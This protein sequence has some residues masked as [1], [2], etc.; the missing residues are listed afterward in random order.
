M[1]EFDIKPLAEAEKESVV[2]GTNTEIE[3]IADIQSLLQSFHSTNIKILETRNK[4]STKSRLSSTSS[5]RDSVSPPPSNS[6]AD[7][8]S[9]SNN[10]LDQS[11]QSTTGITRRRKSRFEPQTKE[12]IVKTEQSLLAIEKNFST[13]TNEGGNGSMTVCPATDIPIHQR[14]PNSTIP[15]FNQNVL[16]A[17]SA[18]TLSMYQ[19][20][21]VTQPGYMGPNQIVL[22][23]FGQQL[24]YNMPQYPEEP[25]KTH[26][27]TQPQAPATRLLTDFF[28]KANNK[29]TT[30]NNVFSSEIGYKSSMLEPNRTA[31][32]PNHQTPASS[33]SSL[34]S[35][36]LSNKPFNATTNNIEP[37]PVNSDRTTL[38]QTSSSLTAQSRVLSR[39]QSADPRLN[40]NLNTPTPPAAPKRKVR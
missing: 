25:V 10:N 37:T 27:I 13:A 16:N 40:P 30:T 14:N 22:P 38:T 23:Q 19:L 1:D 39:S 15:V 26:I 3:E 20:Q 35:T 5:R 31:F 2:P 29:I 18:S 12:E 17:C 33:L 7:S 9:V 34:S 4:K 11:T 28:D 32:F 8:S 6:I 24:A 36:F 21:D